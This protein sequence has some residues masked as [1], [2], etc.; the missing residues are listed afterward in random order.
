M[1]IAILALHEIE[2]TGRTKKKDD[3]GEILCLDLRKREETVRY[4]LIA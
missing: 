1:V 2:K 3:I 4:V